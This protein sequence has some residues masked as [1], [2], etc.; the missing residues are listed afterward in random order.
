[1]PYP[2]KFPVPVHVQHHEGHE[3][4]EFHH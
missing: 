4:L 1:V 2:V 3:G